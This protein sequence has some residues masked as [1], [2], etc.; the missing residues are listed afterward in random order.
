MSIMSG[1]TKCDR[2][3]IGQITRYISVKERLLV[4]LPVEV[5]AWVGFALR[6]N[7]RMS[8]DVTDRVSGEQTLCYFRQLQVLI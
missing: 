2:C 3:L 6:R 5:G 1:R 4:A 8:C 7:G